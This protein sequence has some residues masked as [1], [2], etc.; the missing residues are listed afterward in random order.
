M[1]NESSLSATELLPK[2]IELFAVVILFSPIAIAPAAFFILERL[3][4]AIEPALPSIEDLVPKDIAFSDLFIKLD[5]PSPIAFLE[6]SSTIES[7]PIDIDLS[8][9]ACAYIPNAMAKAP[10]SFPPPLTDES[11]KATPPFQA[12]ELAPNAAPL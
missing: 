3:P 1:E 10:L 4:I 8:E 5:V 7:P 9:L 2:A 11:P 12:L 6:P